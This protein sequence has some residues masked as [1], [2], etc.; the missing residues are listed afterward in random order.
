MLKCCNRLIKKAWINN[1][2]NASSQLFHV[3]E[4]KHAGTK[5]LAVRQ[6]LCPECGTVHDRDINAAKTCLN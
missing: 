5:D 1:K 4:Y 2:I 3:C 6:W